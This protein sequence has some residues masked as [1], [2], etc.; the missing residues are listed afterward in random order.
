MFTNFFNTKNEN[1]SLKYH[2]ILDENDW[3]TIKENSFVMP[4]II[5]KHSERCSISRWVL[6]H[7]ESAYHLEETQV[8]WHLID[9]VSKR[10][11][12]QKIA[13]DLNVIHES[14]QL[15]IIKQGQCVYHASHESIN[16]EKVEEIVQ[17][18]KLS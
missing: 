3:K 7:F 4:Q 16:Y 18:I 14:P 12:S 17:D 9:V 1:S 2:Q 11:I 5:F 10:E 15:L 6:K 8:S 13:N